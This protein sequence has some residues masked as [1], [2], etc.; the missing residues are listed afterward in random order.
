MELGVLEPRQPTAALAKRFRDPKTTTLYTFDRS[1]CQLRRT[2]SS[3]HKSPAVRENHHRRKRPAKKRVD[4]DC[5]KCRTCSCLGLGKLMVHRD[6]DTADRISL[7]AGRKGRQRTN[8]QDRGP[9]SGQ[10]AGPEAE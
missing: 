4:P 6:P 7:R 8:D 2:T 1:D 5:F 9:H 10:E 3:H